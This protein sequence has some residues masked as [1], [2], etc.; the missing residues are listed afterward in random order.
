MGKSNYEGLPNI[1]FNYCEKTDKLQPVMF[2]YVKL[3][4]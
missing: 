2:D 1:K 4:V 3:D